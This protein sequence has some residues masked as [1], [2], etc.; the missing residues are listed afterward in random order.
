MIKKAIEIEGEEDYY[1]SDLWNIFQ[2]VCEHSKY[3]KDVWEN[4][5]ANSE[6]PTPF[7]Y[8]MKEIL[9]DLEFLC[10]DSYKQGNRPLGRIGDNLIRTWATCVANLGHSK[11]KV[12]NKFKHDC[13]G[14]YLSYTLKMMEAFEGAEGERKVN[15]KQWRDLLVEELK[16]YRSGDDRLGETLFQSMNELDMGKRYISDYHEWLRGELSLPDRPR[17]M[18]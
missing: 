8:L 11:N 18:N 5:D 14:Y 7:A 10:N 13:I 16:R 4:I 1:T 12:S 2:S 6:Y 3:D 17:P 15:I 9:S